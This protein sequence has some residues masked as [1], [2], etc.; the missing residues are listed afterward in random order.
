MP[1]Q[2]ARYWIATVPYDLW[3]PYLVPGSE[4]VKGQAEV[5][6]S[7]YKH[8]QFIIYFAKPK[9][10]AF[11]KTKLG[12]NECHLEATRSSRAEAYVWKEETKVPNSEFEFGVKSMKRNNKT[13]WSD[14]L[15]KAREGK[16]SEIPP[17]VQIRCYGNL[18]KIYVVRLKN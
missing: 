9:T 8:W 7:G 14:A 17:D 6:E 18:R 1:S 13:D 3:S 16:F 12:L 15:Q 10:L 2:Q 11:V 5:G 4:Y